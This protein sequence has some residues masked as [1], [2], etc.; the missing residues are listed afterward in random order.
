M[1]DEPRPLSLQDLLKLEGVFS[2]GGQT[3][4]AV[5]QGRVFVNGTVETRRRRKLQAGD[6]VEVDPPSGLRLVVG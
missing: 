5:Q 3:K 1:I 6:V 2:T 4:L